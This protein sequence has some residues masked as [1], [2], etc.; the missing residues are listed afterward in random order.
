MM[1]GFT[2]GFC[3]SKEGCRRAPAE[4]GKVNSEASYIYVLKKKKTLWKWGE[5][6]EGCTLEKASL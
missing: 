1:H 6:Q 2:W 3:K 5:R 4:M